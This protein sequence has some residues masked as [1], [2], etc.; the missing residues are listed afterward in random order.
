MG[1]PLDPPDRK[2]PPLVRVV[3]HLSAQIVLR[4][5]FIVVFFALALWLVYLLRKPIS[6][7]LIAIF[8]AVA[9]SGPVNWLDQWMKRGFAIT[10]V[11]L[12]LLL[13]PIGIGALIVPPLVTQTNNL[14]QNLPQ[15][16][17]DVQN[18]VEKNER[19]RSLEADYNITGQL[20]E[21][22]ETLPGRIGDAANVL[23]DIGLGVVNSLFA[24]FTI[25]VLTAFLLGSGHKWV[26]RAIDL[27]PPRHAARIRS[28]TNHMGK[29]VG[30]Y[31][32]GVLAQATVAAVSAYIV[33]II[34]DVPFAAA[35]AIIIFF[36]DLVP[37]IGATIGA[38]L[39]G[40]VTVF[41]DFP[42]ATI[43][44]AIYSIIYQQVENTLIQP[45]IQKRA[46]NVHPFIVL[47]AVLFGSTL[48]GVLGALVAIPVAASVQ[49]GIREWWEYRS[50]QARAEL[51][52]GAVPPEDVP[53]P[54][55]GSVV[56]P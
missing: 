41:A 40:V 23:G 28:A 3:P 35:L 47:V 8:L 11:Y 24:L 4:T 39:V 42:T 53:P 50:D 29:A 21:Q 34:L 12:A 44:W 31:V 14:I 2:E 13:I 7:V 26:Q 49:I 9:L 18:Y 37:L 30:G 1:V 16:A 6:W 46:V 20:Q 32:G 52:A 56:T 27:R 51:T 43:V 10:I 15:Y 22:A 25:L 54:A 17:Q 55:G 19:L 5:L 36:A 33:L 48:L 45:Q 38:V